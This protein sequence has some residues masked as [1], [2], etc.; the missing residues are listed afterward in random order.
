[1]QF[2]NLA[3]GLVNEWQHD[4]ERQSLL[5][6]H[7][8]SQRIAMVGKVAGKDSSQMQITAISGRELIDMLTDGISQHADLL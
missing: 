3:G 2:V 5:G 6:Q 7:I 4:V 8:G 1:M